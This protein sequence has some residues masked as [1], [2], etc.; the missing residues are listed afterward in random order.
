MCYNEIKAKI[1]GNRL[2]LEL[3]KTDVDSS[4]GVDL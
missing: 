2:R 1:N 3:W 4:V